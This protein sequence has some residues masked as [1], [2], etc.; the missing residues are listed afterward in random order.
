V[1]CSLLP[2]KTL[3]ESFESDALA[4]NGCSFE[5]FGWSSSFALDDSLDVSGLAWRAGCR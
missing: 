1:S 5:S 3:E 2:M 4:L